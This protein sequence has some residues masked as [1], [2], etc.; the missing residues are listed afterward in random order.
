LIN[1]LRAS[2]T[3]AARPLAPV[4]AELLRLDP[5]RTVDLRLAKV[6]QIGGRRRGLEVTLEAFNVTNF[7][8]Y[9]PVTI[10]RNINS[11]SFLE[12]RS[13]RSARQIQWGLRYIF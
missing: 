6:L 5:Y 7:V 1:D 10:N 9:N 11:P 3:T 4:S 13:A 8:N 12:R 2:V